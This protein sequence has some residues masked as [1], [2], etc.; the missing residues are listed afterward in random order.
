MTSNLIITS[1]NRLIGLIGFIIFIIAPMGPRTTGSAQQGVAVDVALVLA[2][3]CSYSVNAEEYELQMQG[4]AQAF[5]STD[6]IKAIENG[7]LGRIAV[8]LVQWSSWN[9]Q[10]LAVPWRVVADATS[11][12]ALAD[13]LSRVPRGAAPGAT[14]ISAAIEMGTALHYRSP[15]SAQ[16]RVID[17]SADGFNNSGPLPEAA[18]NRAVTF[19]ITVNGLTILN[20]VHYLHHYFENRVAA[21]PGHFVM[22]ANDYQA[23]AEAIA[24]KLLRE[25]KGPPIS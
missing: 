24:R 23:Y 19:G 6:I 18:R 20:E 1:H 14:S 10:Y 22:I 13:E 16:R 11:S 17:V 21:G 5:L 2:V 4:L 9:S 3:D 25:I 7:P 8:S 12:L 15:F